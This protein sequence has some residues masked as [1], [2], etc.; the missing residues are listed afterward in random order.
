V[1]LPWYGK[2]GSR[3]L[4]SNR[5]PVIIMPILVSPDPKVIRVFQI[6]PSQNTVNMY[7][8][9]MANLC[10]D[11]VTHTT[12]VSKYF[13]VATC[14]F[15]CPSDLHVFS[16]HLGPVCAKTGLDQDLRM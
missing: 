2:S 10:I 13:W 15:S 16:N 9:H 4:R 12:C 7:T 6:R 3:D 5:G 1:R 8:C 14:V 11:W